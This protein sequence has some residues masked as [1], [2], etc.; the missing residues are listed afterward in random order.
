[1]YAYKVINTP[2]EF[3]HYYDQLLSICVKIYK[4]HKE[5]NSNAELLFKQIS[6]LANNPLGFVLIVV[7]EDDVIITLL[8]ALAIPSLDNSW[9]EIVALWGPRVASKIK[10]EGWD[11]FK[12]YMFENFNISRAYASVLRSPEKFYEWFYKPLGFTKCGY[13][14]EVKF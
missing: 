3:L 5:F 8:I 14:M 2:E 12:K 13:I 7:N 11:I 4:K 1:M 10:H 9:A 6:L